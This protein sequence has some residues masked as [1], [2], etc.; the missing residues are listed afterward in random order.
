M[1]AKSRKHIGR[2]MMVFLVLAC[3][4]GALPVYGAEIPVAGAAKQGEAGSLPVLGKGREEETTEDPWFWVL[5]AT[6]FA[7]GVGFAVGV[8]LLVGRKKKKGRTLQVPEVPAM[9]EEPVGMRSETVMNQEAAPDDAKG[10][11]NRPVPTQFLVLRRTDNLGLVFRA[12]IRDVVRIGRL[13]TQDIVLTDPK[14]SKRHCEVILRGNL[15]YAKDCNS[16]NKT[17]YRGMQIY[18]ETPITIGGILK[19]GDYEYCVDL[20]QG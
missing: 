15:L 19:I 3:L 2:V 6:L 8:V 16:T 17:F 11:W 10:L 9:P 14:V 7:V 13:G 12:P 1:G 5:P 18:E 20:V 4:A